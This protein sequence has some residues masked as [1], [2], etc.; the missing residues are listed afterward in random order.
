VTPFTGFMD[1]SVDPVQNGEP[2]TFLGEGP[3]DPSFDS[4]F[5]D[6]IDWSS[7]GPSQVRMQFSSLIRAEHNLYGTTDR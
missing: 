6:Y 4:E 1:H 7:A 5:S 2:F 3:E